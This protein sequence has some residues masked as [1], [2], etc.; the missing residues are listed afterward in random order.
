MLNFGTTGAP[1]EFANVRKRNHWEA[2]RLPLTGARHPGFRTEDSG[3]RAAI[4]A[5]ANREVG[6]MSAI[7]TFEGNY[8]SALG[9]S[10]T[11]ADE[12]TRK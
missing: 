4:R 11:A 5:G 10:G 7:W 8:S 2:L 3:F 6:F 1:I 9:H 12:P